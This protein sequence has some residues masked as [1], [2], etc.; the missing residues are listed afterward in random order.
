MFALNTDR[1]SR[2]TKGE[3]QGKEIRSPSHWFNG[4]RWRGWWKCS[5]K[6]HV[7]G[8]SRREHGSHAPPLD[9]PS[10]LSAVKAI[11]LK[12]LKTWQ[13]A[14][15][16][17]SADELGHPTSSCPLELIAVASTTTGA[18]LNQ[19]TTTKSDDPF[20]RYQLL[21]P[22]VKNNSHANIVCAEPVGVWTRFNLELWVKGYGSKGMWQEGCF[23]PVWE[24][25]QVAG[26]W[27]QHQ[28]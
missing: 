23:W 27:R 20:V 6:H 18:C 7:E 28:E 3:V 2:S 19:P 11:Q 13:T 25:V 1:M 26:I 17:D 8:V 12:V 24:K 9:R 21:L 16:A 5:M 22:T 14:L 4:L 15:W 10:N